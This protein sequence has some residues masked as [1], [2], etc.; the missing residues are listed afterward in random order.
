MIIGVSRRCD[1]PRFQFDWFR[2]YLA[3]GFADGGK[4]NHEPN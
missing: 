3:A 1:I 4:A 2:E